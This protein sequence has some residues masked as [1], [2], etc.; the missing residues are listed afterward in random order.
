[1]DARALRRLDRLCSAE[2][3]FLY[4]ARQ[5]ADDRAFDVAGDGFHRFVVARLREGKAGFHDVHLQG[6]QLQQD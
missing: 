3:A 6:G 5:A 4:G 2:D 1:M